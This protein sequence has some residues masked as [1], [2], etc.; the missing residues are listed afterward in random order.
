MSP[1][2]TVRRL[3]ACFA[4]GDLQAVLKLLDP[5][6]EWITPPTLP[7]SRG[8]YRGRDEVSS[9]FEDFG[10]ALERP[11]VVP[12]RIL[13]CGGVVVALGRESGQA[14]QTGHAFSV[15]FAHVLT[16]NAGQITSL[17]GH[18]D[19]ATICAAFDPHGVSAEPSATSLA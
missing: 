12:D 3:Y 16:V 14:R 4:A 7:W 18:V 15:P 6:V 1:T 2:E 10:S 17:R 13:D 19:T 11:A 9:Y 8:T 5:H